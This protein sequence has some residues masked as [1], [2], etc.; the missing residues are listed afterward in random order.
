MQQHFIFMYFCLFFLNKTPLPVIRAAWDSFVVLHVDILSKSI[1][2]SSIN[3]QE[4]KK[5][6]K[7]GL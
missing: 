6:R 5:K 3:F 1:Q 2:I 4:K 7:L